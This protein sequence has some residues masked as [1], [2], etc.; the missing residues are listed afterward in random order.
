[1]TEVVP[2]VGR[3]ARREAE[4]RQPVI[5]QSNGH[6]AY[7]AAASTPGHPGA[8]G[9]AVTGYLPSAT[10]GG[11]SG[12]HPDANGFAPPPNGYAPPANGYT[13]P[14]N[15]YAPPGNGYAPPANGYD[16][17]PNGYAPANGQA[18]GHGQAGGYVPDG[19]ASPSAHGHAYA[20]PSAG[21]ATLT[22]PRP[23]SSMPPRPVEA[24][25]DRPVP[26]VRTFTP[27]APGGHGDPGDGGDEMRG[28]HATEWGQGF[29]RVI[30]WTLL[31]TLVPGA[32]MIA[33]GRRALG[34]SIVGFWMLLALGGVAVLALTDPVAF[35]AHN[36]LAH[37]ERLTYLAGVI[38]LLAVLWGAHVVASH[39][40]L[41]RF[42]TLTGL[43]SALAWTLVT[44]L[45]GGGVAT[46]VLR[47]QELKLGQETIDSVFSDGGAFNGAKGGPDVSKA[48]PWANTPRVNILLIGSDAGAD[49]T[50]VRTDTLI[51][52]SIDTRTGNLVTISLP[53][54]LEHVPFPPDSP[55]ARD[56]PTGYYCAGDQCMINA[57]WQF[58]EEHKAQYYKGVKN[59]G[60][61]A[62]V[63][64]VEQALGL[65]IDNYA[66]VNLRGFMQFVDAIGGLQL[67]VK[68]RI[69]VGG[70]HDA[71]GREVGVTS[72]IEPG[73]Q[74]L[75]GYLSL[76][77]ARSRS[78]SDDFER[79]RRQRCVIAALTKQAEP[80]KLA[81][82]ITGILTAAKQNIRTSI[83]VSD[84]DAWVTLALK[85]KKGHQTSLPLTN[86]VISPG[87]PD[88]EK[89]HALVSEALTKPTP[90]ASAK[91]VTPAGAS[92]GATP[93]K[94]KKP[95]KSPTV[96]ETGDAVDVNDVC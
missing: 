49:R 91:P 58:G 77:F 3:R 9:D 56:Y 20:P 6:V 72:Y 48:D 87:D 71:S 66:M 14:A 96:R 18:N 11:S 85:V 13:P 61:K 29:E 73:R 79:M 22:A 89:I 52:A 81:L 57:L 8:Q 24:R 93:K 75:D 95:T 55:Q 35:V 51:V 23:G 19:V 40:Q 90:T 1:M 41:R 82:N 27:G 31:G 60:L 34:W 47:A 21:A 39:V 70:H 17:R 32:G 42:A 38:V 62:T 45:V 28:R 36:L 84:I 12:W 5:E 86:S 94:T 64:G 50:G 46:A 54:N 33:A 83:P 76:W 10:A 44:V 68:R 59:P 63:D 7:G 15:G 67:N 25:D 26:P 30:G 92:P 78:D 43:Q 88:F 74:L 37:P 16:A 80:Q 69:P 2:L 53:R 65:K 4:A